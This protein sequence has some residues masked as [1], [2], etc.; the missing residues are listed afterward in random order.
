MIKFL[1]KKHFSIKTKL[2][3]NFKAQIAKNYYILRFLLPDN[4]S[5]LGIKTCQ[6]IMIES[7]VPELGK[8]ISKP[9]QP[10][11]D[12]NDKGFLDILVKV[13][14]KVEGNRDYGAFSNHLISLEEGQVVNL[15][16][17]YG[18]IAYNGK[19]ELQ[20]GDITHRFKKF[21]LIAGG[22]GVAPMFQMIN[23]IHNLKGDRTA[24][25]LIYATRHP[26]ELCFAD[27]LVK[28]DIKGR[29]HFYPVCNN[30]DSEKWKY[31]IGTIQP[32]LIDDLMPSPNGEYVY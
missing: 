1:F 4:D 9:F 19:G 24:V 31:G 3:F 11:S 20:C 27:D 10:I 2:T 6:H 13:Y 17:P 8:T 5:T 28:Y 32:Q 29:L 23:R 16:G 7:E 18:N 26:D 21:G 12:T 30:V 22:S 25:S 15:Y 14:Q